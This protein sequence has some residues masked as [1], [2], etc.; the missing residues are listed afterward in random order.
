M[1]Q[2]NYFVYTFIGVLFSLSMVGQTSLSGRV[3]DVEGRPLPFAHVECLTASQ[4]MVADSLGR[5]TWVDLPRG[6]HQLRVTYLG[7]APQEVAAMAG[8]TMVEIRLAMLPNAVDE[9]V[10]TGTMKAVTRLES[11]VPVEVFR[12]SF[13]Q[14]NPT[15]NVF[16]ALQQVNGV[17][18]Q[19]NCSV[20]NTGDIH[21]NGLE[22]PYTMV[23]IDGMP[24]VSSLATVYGLMGIPNA[25]IERMEVVKGPASSLYGSEAI[26][27]LINIITR[28]P[29]QAAAVSA[30]VMAT[31]W[32][33]ANIDVGI[34][35]KAG[36][37][38][39]M[40][41]GVNYFNYSLPT[42]RNGD[43]FTD[44]TLQERL[45]VFQK[46]QF[47]RRYGRV[48]SLAGR[49][50]WE[51]RWG[52][53]LDWTPAD[54]GGEEVYG[55]AITTHRWE[56][57]G[58]YQ[59]PTAEH[60]MLSWSLNGHAQDAAYGNTP[61]I[62]QQNIGFGQ[63]VWDKSTARHDWLAGAALRYTFYD[64]NTPATGGEAASPTNA[65]ER[66][67]LPGLF[68][69]DE[70][71]IAPQH[72]LLMGLRYDY[73]TAHGSILTPR[74]AYKWS[75]SPTSILRLNAGTGF[76]VVNLFTED[77]AALTGARSVIIAE[78]L[79]PER[80]YNLNLNFLRKICRLDGLSA[81][82]EASAWYTY[83]TNVILPDY[84]TD[85]NAI[86]YANLDGYAVSRGASASA[87]IDW[88]N[89]WNVQLG[90]TLQEVTSV[91][92]GVSDWQP[93]TERFSGTW[94]VQYEWGDG[95]W[96][97]DYTGSV[98]SPMR[99]PTLGALDPR[100]ELS[101]WWSLQNVQL[102]Y[103][104]SPKMQWYAGIKNLLNWTPWKHLDAPLIARAHDP[105][106]RQVVF[107]A[108]GQAVATPENPYALTF[109]PTYMY[110]PN[111]GL[112]VFLGIR[113][114]MQ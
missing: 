19:L 48:F 50:F 72:K 69:Q 9:V 10:V 83:F 41:T 86:V 53:E 57:L 98:Y 35:R 23:L 101:P 68:V 70:W 77:H 97:A 30:D 73:H 66:V 78:A 26:G 42:D 94:A 49:Y 109:D 106:D 15:P 1:H 40:L 63:L 96:R 71:R 13:F 21:I 46:W 91:E 108:Q 25:L 17:R 113:M 58:Q 36:E 34:R 56:L 105:F 11:A 74:M 52:G 65:P 47:N 33:E 59:L 82:V 90:A 20:C 4:A 99:L 7:Y 114:K 28:S 110:A 95:R 76:R 24:I 2:I 89:G 92:Q 12:P 32:G 60:L 103:A 38:A 45:S 112:R 14:Q 75:I 100:P 27:G 107:D 88:P 16:E 31:S 64:D 3:L 62:A 102:T 55:E 39:T 61:Y 85:P 79:N 5:F 44:V 80:S 6:G 43:N 51:D 93:L 67:W 37:K 29:Q 22:G 104:P 81:N 87:D 84:D 54:R 111:Q 8:D 18:P